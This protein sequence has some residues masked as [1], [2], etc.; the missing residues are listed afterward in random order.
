MPVFS[1]IGRE[2][3]RDGIGGYRT[4]RG[5]LRDRIQGLDVGFMNA[6]LRWKFKRFHMGKQNVYLGLNAFVDGGIVTRDYDMSFRG[7]NNPEMKQIQMYNTHIDTTISDSFHAAG[8]AGF[9]IAINQN[10]IIAI[11]YAK[12]FDKRDG[13]G[14]LYINTGYLF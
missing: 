14:S 1:N 10:F 13:N 5:I 12:P 9:R 8:G 7:D 3:D 11:D 2:Y 4:V 6:E